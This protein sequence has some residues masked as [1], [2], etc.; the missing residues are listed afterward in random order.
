MLK[1]EDHILYVFYRL[2]KSEIK[3]D[4]LSFFMIFFM[5][6]VFIGFVVYLIV[7]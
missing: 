1:D 6:F 4:I 5:I 3:N 2:K 7:I